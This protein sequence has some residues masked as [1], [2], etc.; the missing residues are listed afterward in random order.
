MAKSDLQEFMEKA[1]A[2]KIGEKLELV[3]T[4]NL[5]KEINQMGQIGNMVNDIGAVRF[6]DIWKRT[7]K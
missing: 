1:F 6:V 7:K 4:E 5:K 2:A 3:V